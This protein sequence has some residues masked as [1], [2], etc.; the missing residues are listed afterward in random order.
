[1]EQED[2]VATLLNMGFEN[3]DE[4]THALLLSKNDINEAVAILTNEHSTYNLRSEDVE[5]KDAPTSQALVPCVAP[6]PYESMVE[7]Q[8]DKSVSPNKMESLPVVS[9]GFPTTNLYELESLVFTDRWSIPYKKE[10]SLGKCLISATQL[11]EEGLCEVHDSCKRFIEYC[12]PEAFKKLLTSGAVR[13]WGL[14]VQDGVRNMLHLFLNLAVARM[15]YEPVSEAVCH[16]LDKAFD[17]ESEFHIKNKHKLS[18]SHWMDVFGPGQAFALCKS[19][20]EPYGWLVDLINKFGQLGGFQEIQNLFSNETIPGSGMC[21]LLSPLSKCAEFLNPTKVCSYLSP[22]MNTCIQYIKSLT[23]DDIKSKNIGCVSDLLRAMKMLCLHLWPQQVSLMNSLCLEVIL[24]MLKC[25]HFNARMNGLKEVMKLIDDCTSM[26]FSKIAIDTDSLLSWLAENKVLSIALEGNIDQVQYSDKIKGIIEFIGHRLSIDELSKIW[27]MQEGQNAQIV[28]NIHAIMCAASSKFNAEQFDHLVCLI[29]ET[30]KGGNDQMR[31]R[32]IAF[33]GRIGKET[34]QGKTST[35]ILDLLWE[36]AHSAEIP[37]SLVESALEEHFTILGEVSHKDQTRKQ[38]SVRCI[39]DIRKGES[40]LPSL[41]LL[42]NICKNILKSGIYKQDKA[43]LHELNKT[44]DIIK[45][46]T[47]SLSKCHEQA[48]NIVGEG[49]LSPVIFVDGRYTHKEYLEEHLN[50]LRFLLQEGSQYLPWNRAKDIWD[51]LISNPDACDYDK[52]VCFEWFNNC[53]QDLEAD[54]QSLLFQQKLLKLDPALI[55][56]QGFDCYKTY[57][58]SVNVSE[59]KLKR[60]VSGL[61]VEKLELSGS[62]FLWQVALSAEDYIADLAI[63][64]LWEVSYQALSPKLKK[65]LLSL[66]KRFI[67]E[68][69]KRLECVAGAL[70]GTAMFTAV[71]N[72]T[73]T[74]TAM[75][76]SEVATCPA[77]TRKAS[78]QN[79]CRLLQIAKYYVS[80]VE[81]AF[82]STRTILPH[83]SSFL[84]YPIFLRIYVDFTKEEYTLVS[85]SNETL[86]SVEERIAQHIQLPTSQIQIFQGETA[87]SRFRDQ[88]L[89]GQFN[90][91]DK[92]VL[93]VKCSTSTTATLAPQDSASFVDCG[94]SS[95]SEAS[96][97]N[98]HQSFLL[99][100]EKLL[101]GVVMATGGQA[102]DM[103]YQLATL[104]DANITAQVRILLHLIPTDPAVLDALDSI[105]AKKIIEIPSPSE[106]PKGSPRS[107]PKK[108]NVTSP[109]RE[110]NDIPKETLKELF[111]VATQTPFKLLYNLEVLSGKLMPVMQDAG[112]IQSARIFTEDFHSAGGLKLVLSILQKDSISHEVDYYIRQGCYMASLSIAR[113]LLCGQ[114]GLEL[115]FSTVPTYHDLGSNKEAVIDFPIYSSSRNNDAGGGSDLWFLNCTKAIESIKLPDLVD[116]LTTLMRLAWAAAAG[117]L[118]LA[119][120]VLPTKDSYSHSGRRSRQSSTGSNTSSSS[121]SSDGFGLF[122]GVCCQQE[123]VSYKDSLLAQK[124][125]EFLITCIQ[126]R[127]DVFGRFSTLPCVS[128]FIIDTLLGSPSPD[129]RQCALEQFLKLSKVKTVSCTPPRHFLLKVLLKAR[130]PLWVPSS[131]TRGA[132]QRLLSQCTE[133]FELGCR[134]LNG[135]TDAEQKSLQIDAKQMIEDEIAWLQGFSPSTSQNLQ[136]ADS[137][138]LAGHFRL[139]RTLLTCEGILKEEVGKVL[140]P[141]LLANFLFPA[142]HMISAGTACTASEVSQSFIPR[143]TTYESRVAAFEV[144]VELATNCAENLEKIAKQLLA[145]HH[146]VKPELAKEYEYEPLVAGRAECGYVGLKNAGATCYM[147]SVIQQLYMQPGARESILSVDENNPDEESLFY[148]LQIVFGHLLESQLQYHSPENFWKTCRLWGQPINVRE[149]QDAFEF[150][151]H[152]IDQVDEYLKKNGWDPVFKLKYEGSFSDQKICDGCPHR[153]EREEMFMALNL[154]VKS[155]SLLDSLDQFVKGE[156][157]EG[158][159]AYFCEKCKE[160]R[161]AVKRTCIKNL[162]P[163]LVIQLKRFDYDWEANRSLKF[164]DY[165]K[166]P[167]QLDMAPYT[168]EGIQEK[169]SFKPDDDNDNQVVP[170][171]GNVKRIGGT[172][173][174]LVGVVVHSGQAN[175]G[176]YYSYIKERRSDNQIQLGKWFKFNDTT[177]EEFVMNDAM[178]EAECFGGTYK[179]KVRDSSSSYPEIRQRYWNAYMLFYEKL[180]EAARTPRTPRKTPNKFSFRKS[181][182][183]NTPGS[184]LK[185]SPSSQG[186]HHHHRDSLSQLTQLVDK[187]ER[188]GLFLDKM[189]ARIQQV[190]KEENL[191]FMH[192]RDIYNDSYFSFIQRLARANMKHMECTDYSKYAVNSILPLSVNFLFNTYLRYKRKNSSVMCDW[193]DFIETTV[194]ICKEAAFWFIDFLGSDVGL[195]Y[196][197]PFLL[198]CPNREVRQMFARIVEKACANYL[199]HGGQTVSPSLDRIVT[200]LLDMLNQDVPDNCR[201]CSQYFWLLSMYAQLGHKACVHLLEK[202]AF[203]KF[204]VFL[205]GPAAADMQNGD[206]FQRRWSPIQTQEFGSLHTAMSSLILSTDLVPLRTCDPAQYVERA[207]AWSPSDTFITMPEEICGAL[208]GAGATRYLQEV[209]SACR[210]VSGSISPFIDMLVQCSFCNETFSTAVIGHVMIQYSSVPSNELKNLSHLLQEILTMEDPLQFIRVQQVI[211]GIAQS[212]GPSV[213]GMLDI[214]RANQMNDSRRSYQ[215]VKFLVSLSHKCSLAKD[216]LMQTPSKWQWAVN[217]LKKM[218]SEHT[219]WGPQ[220]N[221]P[222]SNEDSNTK[223]FQRTVSAQD[224]LAEATALLTGLESPE[225]EEMVMDLDEDDK[226]SGLQMK[227]PDTPQIPSSD[228]GD[229]YRKLR[230]KYLRRVQRRND[231]DSIDS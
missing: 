32:L 178:L 53:L 103:L 144:L 225:S 221:L 27:N 96:G 113:Y 8:V 7:D 227:I 187:G 72:A 89:M 21:A 189:P 218:M 129:V 165:F 156:L 180:E 145:M 186:D 133:Y 140:V 176:H 58:E 115:A 20:S 159:N 75:S 195:S 119:N 220:G 16:V 109:T 120:C 152:L 49:Q 36:L 125:L 170:T 112:T 79:I 131:S 28:D 183:E 73:K 71:T 19:S 81:E 147:N 70:G 196:L 74:L 212:A 13:Q 223:T 60:T 198:E 118:N 182:R 130:L 128:D 101:P 206:T 208:Y 188:H 201:T 17:P 143:C 205:L 151:T 105:S 106:V 65:D 91:I 142:S 93:I 63:K 10:E 210:E 226:T 61:V 104:D 173:Y 18:M 85:H 203:Q 56:C 14:E 181:D 9:T 121:E 122:G 31:K 168:A 50:F 164:D 137:A 197:K 179:A 111:D 150:F 172:M 25:P 166:F 88:R 51:T 35:K 80:S 46:I 2:N 216:Y 82:I 139:I 33:I 66:H 3:I 55:T 67:S 215:G 62:D 167:W 5:M 134:L 207:S 155:H 1:M 222:V 127:T 193:I 213:D 204:L 169:E 100:Q 97:S 231:L 228:D 4:I 107:S 87:L 148:Q 174:E 48:V 153:Y 57:F 160:K 224:T 185:G 163:V 146:Y 162:P 54:T 41:K 124:A 138:L 141:D 149:Q 24:R 6:P 95:I 192:N 84:G 202:N 191:S 219:G 199:S 217:W 39:E 76:V 64:Y 211:D 175:A 154:P 230:S 214:I 177:I 86:G 110:K 34:N 102:F 123:N 229:V 135:L 161:N 40:V 114:T 209:V 98:N 99:E 117:N 29:Q 30:W 158:H 43:A 12:M 22:C 116:T 194:N 38:Y 157:L 26:R 126:M 190:V 94:T 15:K 92:Q 44:H 136:A 42:H 184:G 108:F 45:L 52:E 59:H 77:P 78:L 47:T 11:A 90:F 68:C 23:D 69:Y 200:H 37:T 83:G 132:N 171:A